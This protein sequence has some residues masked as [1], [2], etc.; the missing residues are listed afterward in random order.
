MREFDDR[1]PSGRRELE[2]TEKKKKS[3][4]RKSKSNNSINKKE[5]KA[6][7]E[8]GLNPVLG[9]FAKGRLISNKPQQ[10]LLAPLSTD[11]VVWGTASE[12]EPKTAKGTVFWVVTLLPEQTNT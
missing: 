3:K 1:H 6:L 5:I 4:K 7:G 12:L 11:V 10:H 9:R 8:E 2:K